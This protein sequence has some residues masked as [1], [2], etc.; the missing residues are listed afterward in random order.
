MLSGPILMIFSEKVFLMV[1]DRLVLL[2][3]FLVDLLSLQIDFYVLNPKIS[4][5]FSHF[6]MVLPLGIG[7]E[8]GCHEP[9]GFPVDRKSEN[10]QDHHQNRPHEYVSQTKITG[11]PEIGH[12]LKIKCYMTGFVCILPV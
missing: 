9:C 5:F 7:L 10:H 8:N 2:P 6:A 12:L 1:A 4:L 3:P 11:F